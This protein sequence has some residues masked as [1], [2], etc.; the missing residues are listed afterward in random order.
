MSKDRM[1]NFFD[2][3]LAIIMTILVLDLNLPD[4]PTLEGLW[5]MRLSFF[6]YA[7]SFFWLGTMW[8]HQ[9]QS[10]SKATK[11]NSNCLWWTL[12][13][14]FCSSLIPFTTSFVADNPRSTTAC[15]CISSRRL[16]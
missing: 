14:L 2:A 7:L 6:A 10:W 16:R 1:V 11:V 3:T 9:V 4:S 12:I 13:L 5:D 8:V 15:I